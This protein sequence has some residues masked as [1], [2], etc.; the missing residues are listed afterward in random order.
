MLNAMDTKDIIASAGVIVGV[1]GFALALRQYHIGQKWKKAEFA[2]K[3]LEQ[4][5][6][7]PDIA[8]CCQVLDYSVRRMITPE[9]YKVFTNE[10]FF[11]HSTEILVA[12]LQPE[13]G[14]DAFEWPL[15]I[16]RDSFDRFFGYLEL[17]N[18]YIS[19]ELFRA[20]DVSSLKYWVDQIVHP[21]FIEKKDQHVF[22]NFVNAYGYQGV[23]ELMKKFNVDVPK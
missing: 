16:Y 7:D 8:F 17:I 21:R 1:I 2:A 14:R 23:L 5:H 4:L 22:I 10:A 19:I 3:Q 12:G 20:E 9:K 15:I 11:T 13:T 6:N 18:H